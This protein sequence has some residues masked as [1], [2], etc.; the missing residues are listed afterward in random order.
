M[1]VHGVRKISLS[2]NILSFHFHF[3]L[4]SGIDSLYLGW[5]P[6]SINGSCAYGKV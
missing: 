3:T 1:L 5:I 2:R 4:P 6:N